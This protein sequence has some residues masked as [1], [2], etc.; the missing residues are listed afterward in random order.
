[1]PDTDSVWAA[2]VQAPDAIDASRAITSLM[3]NGV[4]AGRAVASAAATAPAADVAP[5]LQAMNAFGL[6]LWSH[7]LRTMQANAAAMQGFMQLWQGTARRALGEEVEPVIAPARS[8]RR[9]KDPAWTQEAGFD[10]LKQS[11]LLTARWL[12]TLVESADDLDDEARAEIGFLARQYMNAVSPSNF[13]LTNPAVVRKT[14]ASGGLNLMNGAS[15]LLADVA[16]GEG[17]VQ[18]RSDETFELGVSIA[19]TPGKV[20]FQNDLMQLIQYEP[21]TAKVHRRP[22]LFVPPTVNK[23]YLFDLQP[24]T[25][26]FKWLVDQGHTVFAISWVNPDESHAAKDLSSYVTE[27]P[28]AALDAI[29]QATGEASVDLIGYCL[30]GTLAAVTLGYLAGKGEGGRVASATLI[31]TLTDFSDLGEWSVFLGE[32]RL[33]AVDAQLAHKGYVESHDMA[34]VFSAV[35]ANDLIWAPA[36]T[37]YLMGEQAPASDM[38]FWFA[39]G[40]RMPAAMLSEYL[41]R[42]VRD[43]DLAQGRLVIDGVRIDLKAVATPVRFVSLKEDHVSGWE[44]TYKG[45]ELFGGPVSFLL[46]G[47]GHNAGV[48]NPPAAGKHGYWTNDAKPAS[49]EA[50]LD[51]A[52][53]QEGSWWGHWQAGLAG[54]DMIAARKPGSGKLKAI[55][56]A[57]GSY[58]R[59]RR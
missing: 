27:G 34:K 25:S 42:V 15:N 39:D 44:A 57:P 50:W 3:R 30:G 14:L 20:V 40:A 33:K 5:V 17:L 7:P 13:P 23:F 47:S 6:S 1:M 37:H 18:R 48:I 51:G 52:A 59:V 36:V 41:G 35:R 19:A 16:K 55:E 28:V 58:V 8:D 53:R 26:F 12:E 22:I 31:A 54:E 24:Q 32:R 43:N 2:P 46:G 11:Y 49:A 38:L 45:T 21:A 4:E 10:W 9:F 56:A 29:Q